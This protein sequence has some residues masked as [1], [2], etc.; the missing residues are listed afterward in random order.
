MPVL[1]HED[2]DELELQRQEGGEQ[3]NGNFPFQWVMN[4]LKSYMH[5]PAGSS[6]IEVGLVK[7]TWY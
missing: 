3:S 1:D 6:Y 4:E 5:T 2:E 7:F